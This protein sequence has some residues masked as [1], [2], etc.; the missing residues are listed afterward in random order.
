MSGP[1]GSSGPPNRS[2]PP[3]PEKKPAPEKK[4]EVRTH[5]KP[6]KP[7]EPGLAGHT[8]HV[9][10]VLGG[11][12]D[13]QAPR[14]KLPSRSALPAVPPAPKLEGLACHV[15]PATGGL[16]CEPVKPAEAHPASAAS[17][18]LHAFHVNPAVG[19]RVDAHPSARPAHHE[20]TPAEAEQLKRGI[21]LH[22]LEESLHEGHVDPPAS[23]RRRE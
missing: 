8:F 16:V 13:E 20:L 5:E 21:K 7:P 19:G 12:V 14:L 3:V 15:N 9:N 10:P 11:L 2:P 22:Q 23:K 6:L 17:P 4:P 1:S 18:E